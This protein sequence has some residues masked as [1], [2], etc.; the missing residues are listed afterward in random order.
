M[1]R[2]L[3]VILFLFYCFQLSAQKA[4]FIKGSFI[5]AFYSKHDQKIKFVNTFTNQVFYW[6][7][8]KG[9]EP[10]M[11]FANNLLL[12]IDKKNVIVSNFQTGKKNQY[13][14]TGKL[15]PNTLLQL[16]ESDEAIS[17]SHIVTQKQMTYFQKPAGLQYVSAIMSGNEKKISIHWK[18]DDRQFLCFYEVVDTLQLKWQLDISGNSNTSF[19]LNLNGNHLAKW[20]GKETELIET[21]SQKTLQIIGN[22]NRCLR[23]NTKDELICV[24]E[25]NQS[26]SLYSKNKESVYKSAGSMWY[27]DRIVISPDNQESFI[28]WDE[29]CVSDDLDMT[30]GFGSKCVAL[31]KNGLVFLFFDQ[32]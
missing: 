12:A 23:F 1:N 28:A 20:N 16:I 15:I 19:I 27:K 22:N 13:A 32:K 17:I 21:G 5:A 11:W 7:E 14:I 2:F 24:D 4:C 8:Y 25:Q 31:L 18:K 6:Y 29:S 9:S 10:V 3:P 30:I 26:T